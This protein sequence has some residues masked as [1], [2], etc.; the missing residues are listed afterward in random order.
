MA[1]MHLKI[2]V[3]HSNVCINNPLKGYLLC[4]EYTHVKPVI[5]CTEFTF[6]NILMDHEHDNRKMFRGTTVKLKKLLYFFL[7]VCLH[8]RQ[9]V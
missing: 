4:I 3:I 5:K 8:L 7:A 2:K 1:P 9:V 6:R